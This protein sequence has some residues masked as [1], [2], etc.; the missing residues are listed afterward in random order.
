MGKSGS[1]G[2]TRKMNTLGRDIS[3]ILQKGFR[4][5]TSQYAYPLGLTLKKLAFV[6]CFSAIFGKSGR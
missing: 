4:K 2:T 5:Q 1:D 6:L 3:W